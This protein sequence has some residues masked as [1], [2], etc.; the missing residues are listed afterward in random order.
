MTMKPKKLFS[1]LFFLLA[2]GLLCPGWAQ[3][4]YLTGEWVYEGDQSFYIGILESSPA[5]GNDG[6]IY[7]A[8]TNFGGNVE[9]GYILALNPNG[10]IKWIQELGQMYM[11]D[12]PAIAPD[13]T[14][15]VQG[16]KFIGGESVP[17][18]LFALNPA[19][20][21]IK[22]EVNA[23][24]ADTQFVGSP[25]ISKEGVVYIGSTSNKLYAF[26][27]SQ[28]T[29]LWEF[30]AEMPVGATQGIF[31]NPVIDVAGTI[32]CLY[33]SIPNIN[34]A[35]ESF[36]LYAIK[37]SGEPKN[38]GTPYKELYFSYLPSQGIYPAIGP[39]GTIYVAGEHIWALRPDL[40]VKWQLPYFDSFGSPVIAEPYVPGEEYSIVIPNDRQHLL[41][42]TPEGQISWNFAA[43]FGYEVNKPA[44]GKG[45]LICFGASTN[46]SQSTY[47][48]GQLYMLFYYYDWGEPVLL[49]KIQL[50]ERISSAS[51]I[52][53]AGN[54]NL[55][56]VTSRYSVSAWN[57]GVVTGQGA[58]L[59]NTSWPCDRGNLKRNGRVSTAF[60]AYL[61]TQLKVQVE[62]LHLGNYAI[63]LGSK[64]DSAQQS[65]AKEDLIPARNKLN[66]FI[67]EV[68]A[69]KGKT[70]PAREAAL[71]TA[72]AQSI[73]GLLQ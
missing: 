19:D 3:A 7:V 73:V 48:G 22:W 67:N 47:D 9:H 1:A 11:R 60:S 50:D 15:I 14:I 44:I 27:P 37:P 29:K 43:D 8:G 45:R 21:S 55:L 36:R 56:L 51:S 34:N 71:W 16:S 17:N 66:A 23:S 31:S 39:D 5:V 65:L 13:G 69:L 25:A 12:N 52:V 42:V 6:T 68:R 59:A 61:V 40:S 28:G 35:G 46:P 57:I 54:Q 32:Y 53:R 33:H 24:L 10:T 49:D 26:G 30:Q 4:H 64:L 20:G 58:G 63:S 2:L 41:G 70:I 18:V 72:A 38:P 62:A